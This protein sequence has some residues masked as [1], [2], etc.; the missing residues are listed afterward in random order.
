VPK[1]EETEE[2]QIADGLD[3]SVVAPED[4]EALTWTQRVWARCTLSGLWFFLDWVIY[5]FWGWI[6]VPWYNWTV[7]PVFGPVFSC[8]SGLVSWS[9]PEDDLEKLDNEPRVYDESLVQ[10]ESTE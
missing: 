10:D 1:P 3:G 6:V 5:P 9:S 7:L 2:V 8:I 4:S